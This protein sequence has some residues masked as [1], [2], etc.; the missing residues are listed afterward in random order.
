MSNINSLLRKLN[1]FFYQSKRYAHWV[2]D[3]CCGEVPKRLKALRAF[4]KE[5]D[6]AA[7]KSESF[8]ICL[9]KIVTES[10]KFYSFPFR[11]LPTRRVYD[12]F[13]NNMYEL[14]LSA[15][16]ILGEREK[17][18]LGGAM[19]PTVK[20]LNDK[21]IFFMEALDIIVPFMLEEERLLNLFYD[22][23]S[24]LEG[25][26]ELDSLRLNSGDIVFD[27][28]ASLGM[29]SAVA[30]AKGCI[31]HAF[32]PIH[33]II[34]NYLIKTAQWN[35]N[36]KVVEA[37]LWDKNEILEFDIKQD[38]ISSHITEIQNYSN[39][40]KE[41]RMIP[42]FSIDEYIYSNKIERVDFIKADI[43]GAERYMLKGA[44]ETLQQ[45]QPKLSLCTY[46]LPDD[47]KVMKEIILQINPNYV[48]KEQYKKMYCYVPKVQSMCPENN[49]N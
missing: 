47:P 4:E 31:V 13:R 1:S 42:A 21:V 10:I 18:S 27:C 46:H 2:Y 6:N 49:Y 26:Y 39:D 34:D 36:I 37:A 17:I 7:C 22:C 19:F 15:S 3:Y 38:R 33:E 11:P 48:I 30:S 43:E 16:E 35:H 5:L 32:E 12:R 9:Q 20:E 41:K 45:Y 40:T 28:G 29:F 8:K 44:K 14:I 25:P 23:Y 24:F